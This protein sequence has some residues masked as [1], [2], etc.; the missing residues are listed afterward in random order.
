MARQWSALLSIHMVLLL[1]KLIWCY[2]QINLISIELDLLFLVTTIYNQILVVK[3]YSL[4]MFSLIPILINKLDQFQLK[5]L[6]IWIILMKVN[7]KFNIIILII[8]FN[9]LKAVEFQLIV[10]LR[11]STIQR[12]Q[13]WFKEIGTLW[14][15]KINKYRKE[16]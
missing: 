9:S 4:M 7:P 12:I 10:I 11:L 2:R 3:S 14:Q 16:N 13:A 6:E 1:M 8:M 5:I 15:D